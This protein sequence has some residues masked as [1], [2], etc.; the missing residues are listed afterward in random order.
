MR[1]HIHCFDTHHDLI[2][3]TAAWFVE[4]MANSSRDRGSCHIALAGGGTPKPLYLRLAK[5]DLRSQV[6]WSRV[7]LFFGDERHVDPQNPASNY[8]MARAALIDHV[9]INLTHVHR[10]HG[11][12]PADEAAAQYAGLLATEGPLD[13][14]LCGMGG[15]GH[16]A[17]LFPEGPELED[18]Q[19]TV[20][21]TRS[22]VSPFTRISMGLPTLNQARYVVLLVSGEGKAQRLAEVYGQLLS[23]DAPT[24]PAAMLRPESHQLHWFVDAGA[25]SQLPPDALQG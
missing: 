15:D 22:P 18:T 7:H 24:L 23:D 13:I 20:L 6:D 3:N 19:A 16:T 11:E 17:S 2:E 5:P 21:V 14:A 10:I 4:H 25:A 9:P 1:P 8:L 12:L